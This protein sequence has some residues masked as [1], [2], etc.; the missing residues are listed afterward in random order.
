MPAITVYTDPTK[1]GICK[2]PVFSVGDSQAWTF[3]FN[4]GSAL[5]DP[6]AGSAGAVS[7]VLGYKN[8]LEN[9]NYPSAF[10]WV[11]RFNNRHIGSFA[12]AAGVPGSLAFDEPPLGGIL[13]SNGAWMLG[14]EAPSIDQRL[15]SYRKI[16]ADIGGAGYQSPPAIGFAG[17]GTLAAATAVLTGRDGGVQAVNVTTP[18]TGYT[19]APAVGFSGGGGSGAAGTAIIAEGGVVFVVITNPGSGYTSAPA[20]AFTGGGGS[21]AAGSSALFTNQIMGAA[22]SNFGS[23]YTST[24]VVSLSGGGGSGG[25]VEAQ[26]QNGSVVGVVVVNPGTGYNAGA[27]YQLAF[28]GGGGSGADA[29]VLAHIT[30]DTN[31]GTLGAVTLISGGAGYTSAPTVTVVAVGGSGAAASLI[32]SGGA[33]V[34]ATVTNPGSG[35]TNPPLT[36]VTG[37]G[38]SGGAIHAV[39]SGGVVAAIIV[40]VPGSGY[41]APTVAFTNSLGTGGTL[42]AVMPYAG[43]GGINSITKVSGGAGYTAP[44][45]VTLVGGDGTGATAVATWVAVGSTPVVSFVVT[46]PGTGYTIPPAV[47]ISGASG[48]GAAGTAIVTSAGIQS[49]VVVAGGSG[50]E[51]NALLPLVFSGSNLSPATGYATTDSTGRVISATLTGPG[52]YGGPGLPTITVSTGS[53]TGASVVASWMPGLGVSLSISALTLVSGGSG[54]PAGVSGFP[55]NFVGPSITPAQATIDTNGSGVITSVSLTVPGLY[56]QLPTIFIPYFG[57]GAVIQIQGPQPITPL[58]SVSS[59]TVINPGTGYT[60]APSLTFTR[61]GGAN[62]AGSVSAT[63]TTISS[64]TIQSA[65]DSYQAAIDI[66]L[67]PNYNSVLSPAGMLTYDVPFL[68]NPITLEVLKSVT[69]TPATNE[70]TIFGGTSSIYD[71]SLLIIRP[72]VLVQPSLTLQPDNVTYAATFNP[73]TPFVLACLRFRRSMTMDLLIYGGGRLLFS[74][75]LTVYNIIQ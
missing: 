5:Y 60:S 57:S 38:G 74:G 70:R 55:I 2:V 52:I 42:A 12:L 18:G 64:V 69:A 28:S 15:S 11:D 48:S 75:S 17:S 63:S 8:G 73:V 46:N 62:A 65:G 29:T 47:V 33:I 32:I 14:G 43:V 50:Y 25:V 67:T 9:I 45:T 61:G 23:G 49:L 35:Y 4:N 27:T 51:V 41:G 3:Q 7:V 16:Y 58:G 59:L 24:P 40:D 54:Y 56:T 13:G 22:L 19:S 66:S 1:P 37:G 26:I 53:G 34:G 30:T 20:V 44:P 36:V 72:K 6:N 39:V 31:P 21:S 10:Q 71:N 68:K